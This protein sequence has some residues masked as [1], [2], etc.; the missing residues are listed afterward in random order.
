M[1]GKISM[2]GGG[3][4][5]GHLTAWWKM[6]RSEVMLQSR[7]VFG[8][9]AASKRTKNAGSFAAGRKSLPSPSTYH[10]HG[11]QRTPKSQS[12]CISCLLQQFN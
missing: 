1:K 3:S 9:H 6:G 2:V 10:S 5:F 12:N 11:G 7:S 8:T 4:C